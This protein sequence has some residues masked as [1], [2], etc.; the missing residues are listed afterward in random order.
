MGW[1]RCPVE[2]LG[3]WITDLGEKRRLAPLQH[4]SDPGWAPSYR[5]EIA[6]NW[7]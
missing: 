6:G 3:A 5:A 1:R 7:Q 4:Q 2:W